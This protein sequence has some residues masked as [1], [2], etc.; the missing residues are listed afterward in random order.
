MGENRG[1][2]RTHEDDFTEHP[3]D[4]ATPAAIALRELAEAAVQR[5]GSTAELARKLEVAPS[6]IS[7]IRKGLVGAGIE[8]LL[9]LADVLEMDAAK[10]LR[11]CGHPRLAD[12]LVVLQLNAPPRALSALCESIEHLSAPDRDLIR[13][14]VVRLTPADSPVDRTPVTTRSS[15]R[16][17]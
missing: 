3:L 1:R 4:R 16:A 2:Y 6:H 14:L 13:A 11:V 5:V 10:V 12:R 8:M 9:H 15:G 7:R 17:L